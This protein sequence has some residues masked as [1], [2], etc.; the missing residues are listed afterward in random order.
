MTSHED[1]N[2][3]ADAL[4]ADDT[5]VNPPDL[6]ADT[7]LYADAA[8]I[9]RDGEEDHD[10]HL[11][12]NPIHDHDEDED[13]DVHHKR[14]RN[15]SSPVPAAP[16]PPGG[17]LP[18]PSSQTGSTP[19]GLLPTPPGSSHSPTTVWTGGQQQTVP[20]DPTA[21]SL[22]LSN[23]TWYTTDQEVESLFTEFGKVRNMK[24]VEDRINGKSKGTVCVELASPEVAALA[25]DALTGRILHGQ[26]IGITL[27][28]PGLL[29]QLYASGKPG[30]GYGVSVGM[31]GMMGGG[32]AAMGA[33]GPARRRDERKP[34]LP[35]KPYDRPLG[36][37]AG[38]GGRPGGGGVGGPFQPSDMMRFPPVCWSQARLDDRMIHVSCRPRVSDVDLGE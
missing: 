17:I 24:F 31:G 13:E 19:A 28:T 16:S 15:A 1:I 11:S 8:G 22:C 7:A 29:K 18:T 38:A 25:R 5:T 6:Y 21:C 35:P 10:S 30:A 37:G 23:L 33:M 9:R 14:R 2:I 4:V 3:Y 20:S 34:L 36:R 32:V 26:Q 12:H 27:A